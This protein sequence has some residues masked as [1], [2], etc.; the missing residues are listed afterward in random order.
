MTRSGSE[1]QDPSVPPA[2]LAD[3]DL[4]I[5]IA[6]GHE[7][8][9]RQL[10]QRYDRLV[11]YTIFRHTGDRCQSDPQ[12]IDGVASAVWTGMVRAIRRDR[13]KVP[14]SLRAYV[15]GVARNQAISALRKAGSSKNPPTL[16]IDAASGESDPGAADP[17]D[18]AEVMET[19]TALRDCLDLLAGDDRT[20]AEQL[21]MI[22]DRRWRE[23]AEA[24]KMRESTLR[25]R[26]KRVLEQLRG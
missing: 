19:L 12:W 17:A 8:A 18:V 22:L 6:A 21:P 23:A 25:S 1:N 9:L 10:M 24:L 5:A 16:D 15:V 14:E 20:L 2:E 11:R 3:N 7:P 26:W 4:A 13:Y